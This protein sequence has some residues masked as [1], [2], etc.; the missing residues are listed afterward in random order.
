MTEIELYCVHCKTLMFFGDRKD[1][2]PKRLCCK[3]YTKRPK[4]MGGKNDKI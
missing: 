2:N 1:Y 4:Y 3:P